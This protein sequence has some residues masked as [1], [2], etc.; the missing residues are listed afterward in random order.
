[1]LN[2]HD[3]TA[4]RV[5]TDHECFYSIAGQQYPAINTVISATEA[6][7]QKQY[8]AAW[9]VVPENALLSEQAHSRRRLLHSAI[10]HHFRHGSYE[11]AFA[12]KDQQTVAEVMPFWNSVQHVLP[13]ITNPI[14]ME[15]AV[16]HTIGRYAGSVDMVCHFN[17]VP[18]ILDWK[19]AYRPQQS[20]PT[21]N[22]AFQ[23][24]AYA[25][26]I[27][28]MYG[29]HIHTGIFIVALPEEEAHVLQFPLKTFW[30]PWLRRLIGYWQQQDTPTAA[31]TLGV[32]QEEYQL[33]ASRRE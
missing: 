6:E 27:N 1:M 11:L 26:A 4:L 7:Q 5:Y 30:R 29:A 13:R 21:Y 10:E 15:S 28:R 33:N 14:L 19:I 12:D 17:D 9:R 2:H 32:L 23:V 24:A 3:P 16:W 22:F 20:H 31:Q 25:G 8:W 18:C